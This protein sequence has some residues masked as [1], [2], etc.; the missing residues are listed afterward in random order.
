MS[1]KMT[2]Q[3]QFNED[4]FSIEI[5]KELTMRPPRKDEA[6]KAVMDGIIDSAGI[7]ARLPDIIVDY[8]EK[9]L[10][11][12]GVDLYGSGDLN[13][14]NSPLGRYYLRGVFL[15]CGYASDPVKRYRIELHVRNEAVTA[16]ISALLEREGLEFAISSKGTMTVFYLRKGDSVSDFLGVIGANSSRLKFE[17]IRAE[18]E[19]IGN[20]TRTMNFDSGNT[21]RQ[22]DAGAL[23]NSLISKLMNSEEAQNLTP[24]LKMAAEVNLAN[25]GASISELGKLMDPPIGKS[26][27]N[28]RIQKLLEIAKS[29]D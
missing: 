12:D 15:A 20:V 4:S 23:R 2:N 14:M 9:L 21:K 10:Q 24:E 29:L 22:A 26:G 27:M 18:R 16:E 28:H 1:Q 5:K 11:R 17:N 8:I 19:V 13:Y 3:P 25:P 7:E 6:A